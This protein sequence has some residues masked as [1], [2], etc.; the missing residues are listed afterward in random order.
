VVGLPDET[1]G[2]RVVAVVVPA[3]GRAAECA[4]EPLRAWARE[5][6]AS[7]KVPREVMVV[8]SLPR[9]ALGKVVKPELVKAILAGALGAPPS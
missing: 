6:L 1:W 2:D 5:R 4:A 7:Y 8:D 9:N 3:P